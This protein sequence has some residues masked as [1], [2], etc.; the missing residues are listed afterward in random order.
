[1]YYNFGWK[2]LNHP[3]QARHASWQSVCGNWGR[4]WNLWQH[5]QMKRFSA[6]ICLYI[7]W[8]S[9]LPRL[10]SQRNLPVPKSKVKAGTGGPMT[11]VLLWQP[12]VQG[13][14]SPQFL[15]EQQAHPQPTSGRC[16]PLQFMEITKSLCRDNFPHI[17][18]EVPQELTAPQGLL[19]G[20]PWPQWFPQA[21]TRTWH[22]APPTWTWW[23]PPWAL[24]VWGLPPRQ[25]IALCSH[26]GG[27]KTQIPIKV[28]PSWLFIFIGDYLPWT[29][30]EL[31]FSLKYDNGFV[32]NLLHLST[33]FY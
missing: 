12:V 3:W 21:Y 11:R 10:L 22:W 14:W 30:V 4:P 33:A 31:S 9:H 23:P 2:R 27:W 29:F 5:S 24:W 32:F 16:H 15:P 18:V 20:P 7:W 8:R 26:W 19:A 25:L 6:M 17:P 1:M 13:G 28:S